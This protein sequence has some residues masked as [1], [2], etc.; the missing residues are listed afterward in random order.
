MNINEVCW[1]LQVIK[2]MHT[3]VQSAWC[4]TLYSLQNNALL[5][6]ED[7]IQNVSNAS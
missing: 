1:I 6:R 2:N 4:F 5:I 7:K 3:D